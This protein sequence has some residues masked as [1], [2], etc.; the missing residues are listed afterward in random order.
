MFNTIYIITK[1]KNAYLIFCYHI[2]KEAT[3]CA[4]HFHGIRGYEMLQYIHYVNVL[5]Y[6]L[7]V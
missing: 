5:A 4:I 7:L 6:N 3:M 1:N 2:S